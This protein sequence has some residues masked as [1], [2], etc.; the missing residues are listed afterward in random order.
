M[1]K[2]KIFNICNFY[3]LLW[4]LYYFHWQI[5]GFFPLLD[6]L[7]VVF[8]GVGLLISVYYFFVANFYYSL[9]RFYKAMN[10][11]LFVFLIYGIVYILIGDTVVFR[12]NVGINKGSFL[13]GPLR[14]FLP[15]YAFFVFSKKGLLTETGLKIWAVVFFLQ[16]LIFFFY[17][18]TFRGIEMGEYTSGIV[19][20]FVMLLPYLFLIKKRK[21]LPYIFLVIMLYII[22]LGVKRGAILI[23]IVFMVYFVLTKLKTASSSKK[24][25]ALLAI[26]VLLFVGMKMLTNFYNT[27][28]HFQQRVEETKAGNVSGR[29]NIIYRLWNTYSQSN[30]GRLLFGYGGDGSVKISGQYAHNDWIEILVD[31][32]VVGFVIYFAFWLSLFAERRKKNP[33]VYNIITSSILIMFPRTFFSMLYS[34]IEISTSMLLAYCLVLAQKE[35]SLESNNIPFCSKG[36]L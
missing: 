8:L 1:Q 6:R 29:D 7:S 4:I 11:L 19:Y 28:R 34:C 13:I 25:G 36:S 31:E 12:G 2:N 24:V 5:A 16:T 22:L 35:S 32:G 23:G 3:I 20:S 18:T 10:V 9:P 15:F 27:S 21:V 33:F 17:S 14:S 30:M 26:I